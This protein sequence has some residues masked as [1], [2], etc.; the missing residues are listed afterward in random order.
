M[1]NRGI[2]IY[3]IFYPNQDVF[4]DNSTSSALTSR[5]RKPQTIPHYLY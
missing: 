4:G 2:L 1:L 3:G 5:H